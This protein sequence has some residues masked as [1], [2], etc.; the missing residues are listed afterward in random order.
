MP[1]IQPVPA[2]IFSTK[3]GNDLSDRIAPPYD[4]LDHESKGRLV[5]ASPNNISVIDLPHLPPRP[6]GPMRRMSARA[7]PTAIG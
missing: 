6:S 3:A 4:V 5:A 2:I 1:E 7:R